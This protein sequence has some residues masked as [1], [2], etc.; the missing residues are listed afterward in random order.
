MIFLVF[1]PLSLLVNWASSELVPDLFLPLRVLLAVLVMTP[2]MTYLALPWMTRR[3]QWWLH[4][5]QS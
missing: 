5:K 4:P 1:F 3:M 2:V